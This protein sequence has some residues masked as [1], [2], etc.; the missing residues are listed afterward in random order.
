MAWFRNLVVY[1]LTNEQALTAAAMSAQLASHAFTPC[2]DLDEQSIGFVPPVDGG[3]LAFAV[4]GGHIFAALCVERKNL[5]KQVIDRKTR[6]RC[7]EA[8]TSQGFQ[9]GRKQRREIREQVVDELLPKAFSTRSTTRIWFDVVGGWLVIDTASGPRADDVYRYLIRALG[10]LPVSVLRTAISPRAAMTGWIERD[11]APAGF[12]VDQDAELRATG[13]GNATVRFISHT[14]EAD[15]L[16]RHIAAGK[17]CTRL[18]LTWNDRVSFV[19]TEGLVL[20]Q[21]AAL[22]I[23][24]ESDGYSDAQERDL[25][26]M[27]G[28]LRK[29]LIGLVDALGGEVAA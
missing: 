1:R 19:L 7:A 4:P 24:K 22:D 9:P 13:E 26:L 11:E 12:T 25:L 27:A 3:D 16:G 10:G 29:L 5:P 28:E 18:A 15:D 17:Q 23:L 21:L 2:G 14:L 6:E 8:E 20:K